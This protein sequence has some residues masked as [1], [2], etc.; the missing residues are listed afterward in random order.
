MTFLLLHIVL[1]IP[2]FYFFV[3]SFLFQLLFTIPFSVVH[4]IPKF[5]IILYYLQ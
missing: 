3:I 2:S 4:K 5:E 1:F